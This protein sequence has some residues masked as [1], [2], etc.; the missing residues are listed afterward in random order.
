VPV[1]TI[2]SSYLILK[3]NITVAALLGTFLTIIGLFLSEKKTKG[4]IIP[5]EVTAL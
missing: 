1:I 2:A 3:E 4:K 5:E